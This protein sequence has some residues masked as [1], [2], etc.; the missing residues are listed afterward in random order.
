MDKT[1]NY[2]LEI[3][4]TA[5]DIFKNSVGESV[6][7]A[8]LW[9]NGAEVDALKS[10]AY[11]T[12]AP[13]SPSAGDFYYKITKSTPQMALMRYSGSAWMDMTDQAAYGHSKT[14]TWYR[15]DRNG[16]PLDGG[17]AF[18][19]GKTIF[20]DGDDVDSKTVFVCEVE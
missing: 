15:R 20:I 17:S 3:D 13:A 2:Q 14:Y 19:T 9:Q 6:L 11:S 5:G 12:A 18:A 16:N 4:S 10:T 8:R 7:I 1:D